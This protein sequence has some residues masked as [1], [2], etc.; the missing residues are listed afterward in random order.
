MYKKWTFWYS[1]RTN[2]ENDQSWSLNYCI[3]RYQNHQNHWIS[4]SRQ[5]PKLFIWQYVPA[6]IFSTLFAT[7]LVLDDSI[8][9]NL[10]EVVRKNEERFD[11]RWQKIVVLW[12]SVTFKLL[13]ALI[14]FRTKRS[15][16]IDIDGYQKLFLH[17]QNILLWK[18]I[19]KFPS[20]HSWLKL[21]IVE[22][23]ELLEGFFSE[24]ILT[25]A[26][27]AFCRKI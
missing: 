7:M 9:S 23:T 8:K 22:N 11:K 10:A 25:H 2:S 27:F 17:W 12:P 26:N 14:S 21:K 16:K 18:D 19:T 24:W 20:F 15:L 1:A 5:S 6:K 3:F 13:T 4:F